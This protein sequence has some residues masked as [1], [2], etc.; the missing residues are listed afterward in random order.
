MKSI[1]VIEDEPQ[2]RA[3]LQEVLTLSQFDAT[4][5]PNGLVGIDMAQNILPD[6]ILCDVSMPEL[7]GYDVIRILRK[8][9]TTANIPFIFLTA[10]G[11][12]SERRAGMELGASDY[13]TKPFKQDELLRVIKLQ[14]EKKALADRQADEKLNQLRSNINLSLPHELH[15]PLNGIIGS[16]EL[17]LRNQALI[18][19]TERTELAQQIRDSALRLYRLTHNFLLYAELEMRATDPDVAKII[20]LNRH[21]RSSSQRMISQ[22]AERIAKQQGRSADLHLEVEN[23]LLPISE[24]KL[25]KVIEELVDNACKFS[26]EDSPIYVIGHHFEDRYHLDVIDMGHGMTAAQIAHIGAYM[27][28]DRERHE[29][30]GAGLGLMIAKR[31]IELYGGELTIRSTPQQ[32]TIIHCTLPIKQLLTAEE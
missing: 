4:V 31:I 1:L 7:D 8:D 19:D 5:A 12:H 11:Q 28:F 15:T 3:N 23:Q 26:P 9:K 30:Q 22:T 20:Q 18:T 17:L 24:Q 29:Q 21:Q 14:L 16:A 6:L 27:Q 2:I 25:A 13:L 10:Q 32:E